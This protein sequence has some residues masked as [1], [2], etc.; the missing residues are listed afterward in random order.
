MEWS[1][2]VRGRRGWGD[3]KHVRFYPYETG[4]GGEG[5]SSHVFWQNPANAKLRREIIVIE[6]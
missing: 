6:N 4:G 2:I 5:V 1:L 3:T